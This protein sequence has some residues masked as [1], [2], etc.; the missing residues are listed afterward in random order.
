MP[1]T[2]LPPE[3]ILDILQHLY[4]IE[5]KQVSRTC[6][7]YLYSI[8]QPLLRQQ[9]AA[10]RHRKS[11]L[12]CLGQH[13]IKYPCIPLEYYYYS[14]LREKHGPYTPNRSPC[15]DFLGLNGDLYWLEA[16]NS[17]MDE[18]DTEPYSDLRPPSQ[19]LINNLE[20]Q[21][22]HLGIELPASFVKL[23]RNK[24]L[25]SRIPSGFGSFTNLGCSLRKCP[26]KLDNGQGGYIIRFVYDE[27][28]ADFRA[29]YL[30]ATE[31]K[32][33]C[34]LQTVTDPNLSLEDDL[35]K[36]TEA[37]VENGDITQQ[38]LDEA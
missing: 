37:L 38:E 10:Q 30:S 24:E 23:M 26:N 33:Y 14:E 9:L 7:K 34:V 19:E 29:L 6:N 22:R 8:C 11:M 18:I 25:Q 12:S 13:N 36:V 4:P 17:E 2:L 21:A 5:V 28:N 20:N 15:L 31:N 16:P 32:G 3:V 27:E 35:E 1:F